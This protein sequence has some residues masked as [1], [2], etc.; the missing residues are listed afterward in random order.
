VANDDLLLTIDTRLPVIDLPAEIHLCP[1]KSISLDVTQ[2]F[3]ADYLWSDGSSLPTF[4]IY[5]PGLFSVS[6][7]T[8][9][10]SAAHQLQ[11]IEKDTCNINDNVYIPN[12]FSPNNDGINDFFEIGF[13]RDLDITDVSCSIYDRWGTLVYEANVEPIRWDGR[14][15]NNEMNQ[16]VFTYVIKVSYITGGEDRS[17]SFAGNVTLVR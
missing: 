9:C 3:I 13:S 15:H 11:V 12:V 8:E 2:S 6:I 5:S 14:Y 7:S 17:R 1:D 4:Q 16:A 10:D